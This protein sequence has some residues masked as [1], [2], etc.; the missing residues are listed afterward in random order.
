MLVDDLAN[1]RKYLLSKWR[2]NIR[3]LTS[4]QELALSYIYYF[5]LAGEPR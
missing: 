5:C 2:L 4:L 1:L 3:L